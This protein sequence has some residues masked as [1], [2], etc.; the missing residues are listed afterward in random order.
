MAGENT[1]RCDF[2]S[3]AVMQI[4]PNSRHAVIL[5]KD[6]EMHASAAFTPD[7]LIEIAGRLVALAVEFKNATAQKG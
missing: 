4:G 1:F 2:G 5:I 7:T 6:G 3:G